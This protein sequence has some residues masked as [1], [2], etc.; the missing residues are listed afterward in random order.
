VTDVDALHELLRD[1]GFPLELVLVRGAEERSVTV[2]AP[3]GATDG[4]TG[5]SASPDQPV[6]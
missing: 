4:G 3:A 1:A 2:T 5:E 6:H